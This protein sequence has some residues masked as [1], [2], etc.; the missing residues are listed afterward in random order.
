MTDETR[1]EFTEALFDAIREVVAEYGLP[2][3]SVAV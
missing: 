3:E 1:E 2:K